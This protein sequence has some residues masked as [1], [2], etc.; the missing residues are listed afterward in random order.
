LVTD[1]F[2]LRAIQGLRL[3]E[4]YLAGLGIHTA[5]D[6]RVEIDLLGDKDLT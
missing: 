3:M 6:P 5:Q 2:I 4:R 1:C